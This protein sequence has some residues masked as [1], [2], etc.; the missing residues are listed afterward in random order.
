[1]YLRT[2]KENLILFSYSASDLC[3][4]EG[5]GGQ[6]KC[7]AENS[8]GRV[9]TNYTLNVGRFAGPGALNTGEL[10]GVVSSGGLGRYF[11]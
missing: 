11:R 2:Y 10:V 3:I 8:A 5:A 9:E 1:M 6:Y 4:A 7:V